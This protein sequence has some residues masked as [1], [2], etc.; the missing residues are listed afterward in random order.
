MKLR[1]CAKCWAYKPDTGAPKSRQY[2]CADCARV[3]TKQR[4]QRTPLEQAWCG[5]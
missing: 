5:K 4:A 2:R 1:F 3:A